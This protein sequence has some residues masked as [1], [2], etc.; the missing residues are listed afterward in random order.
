MCRAAIVALV[1]LGV[2][3]SL[4]DI[5]RAERHQ[6][7]EISRRSTAEYV[8]MG[9]ELRVVERD[10]DGVPMVPGNAERLRVIGTHRFG[11]IVKVYNDDQ[12][13]RTARIVAPSKN[14]VIWFA[15]SAQADL[16]LHDGP[17]PWTLIQGSEGSGKTTVLSMFVAVE[18]LRHIGYEREIGV[19][20]PTFNRL[21]HVKREIKRWWRPSWYRFSERSQKY[22]FVVGPSVQLVSAVQ[23]SEEA[24]S[25]IQ[26]ANWVAH[27]G[28]ELQ[29]HHEREADIEARGRSAPHGWYPRLNTSTFKDSPAWRDFRNACVANSNEVD[30]SKRA[31]SVVKLLG[32]ESPFIPTAHWDRLLNSGT[33][34]WRE[35]QR[36]VLALEVGPESQLYHCWSRA[37]ND[38]QPQNLRPLPLGAVD[39]TAEVLAH[40]GPNIQLLIGHDPGQR[41][42]VSIFLKA[43]RFL[44]DVRRGDSRPRWFVVDGV[45]S[46]M[47]TVHAHV[48]E[49]LKRVRDRWNCNGLDRKGNPDIGGRQA[50]VRIDP[51]TRSGDEHPGRDVYTIW[52]QAGLLTKAAAYKPNS[53][54]PVT[55]K[56]ESRIDMVNTL[57]CATDARG[58]VRR[59][60][61]LCDDRNA[62]EKGVGRA[63]EALVEAFETMER[64]DSGDAE[65]EKKDKNDRSHYPCCVGYALWQVEAPRLGMVA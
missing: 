24:G 34:T 4:S 18:A 7:A 6:L 32:R 17:A 49:V 65:H 20:A 13:N 16:I 46:P 43:Y 10:P 52:R 60:F 56:R 3:V 14:P 8:D 15:S 19:T 53:T 45:T 30:E 23:R 31:W 55:I 40:S 41:Q 47:S 12:R 36:R 61:V 27:A 63:V 59:L 33:M 58:E 28:D 51:H 35:Y 57:L 11:G 5:T 37:T 50:L 29:D 9:I 64:N 62:Y 26:G 2:T 22:T 1:C 21:A 44:D 38:N 48:Q 39:C 54:D 25:P 42:H